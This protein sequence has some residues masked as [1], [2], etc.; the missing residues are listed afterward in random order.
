VKSYPTTHYLFSLFYL[1][2]MDLNSVVYSGV[3]RF[4]SFIH[5]TVELLLNKKEDLTP[6]ALSPAISNG[7]A[8]NISPSSL[9]SSIPV[10]PEPNALKT[11]TE[12]KGP[13]QEEKKSLKVCIPSIRMEDDRS[14]SAQTPVGTHNGEKTLVGSLNEDK[15]VKRAKLSNE[16]LGATRENKI[17]KAR[18]E[19]NVLHSLPSAKQF[20]PNR[21]SDANGVLEPDKRPLVLT[22]TLK[23]GNKSEDQAETPRKRYADGNFKQPVVSTGGLKLEKKAEN[24]VEEVSRKPFDPYVRFTIYIYIF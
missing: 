7:A 16:A 20:S 23:N 18:A 21:K 24:Q 6:E 22:E 19:D 5:K 9:P 10:P 1:E 8:G 3:R 12:V 2:I 4:C 13:R 17:R 14:N 11:G 15:V